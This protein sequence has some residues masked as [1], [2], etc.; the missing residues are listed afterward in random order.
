MITKLFSKTFDYL[1]NCYVMHD[2]CYR[3]N[4]KPK[5]IMRSKN[6]GKKKIYK[7]L[8]IKSVLHIYQ[9]WFSRNQ[10][11]MRGEIVSI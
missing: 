6:I 10:C 2:D 7:S 11:T 5:S 9:V 8:I 3:F 1:M 4:A